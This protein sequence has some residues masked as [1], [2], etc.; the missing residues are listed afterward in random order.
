MFRVIEIIWYAM[1][2]LKAFIGKRVKMSDEDLNSIIS[3]FSRRTIH[4]NEFL[5]KQKDICNELVFIEKG[6]FRHYHY[7]AEGKEATACFLLEN[8][9][10]FEVVS[11]LTRVPSQEIM[12]ALEDSVIYS[13]NHHTLQQLYLKYP[14]LERFGRILME[15][16]FAEF[17]KIVLSQLR[18]T[19]E[20]RYL[21]LL[22]EQPELFQ[23]VPLKHI[24]SFLGINNTSFSRIRKEIMSNA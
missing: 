1:E 5:I 23:R 18:E 13:I 7:T 8:N 9:F 16:Q 6:I 12:Q 19:A 17:K 21:T 2:K 22:E 10:A 20:D 15:E 11:F 24:A 14:L 4:K 3:L